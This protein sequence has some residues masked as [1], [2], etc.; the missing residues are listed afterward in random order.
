MKRP[1]EKRDSDITKVDKHTFRDPV[2]QDRSALAGR[3]KEKA[4]TIWLFNKDAAV[5]WTRKKPADKH[6]M[7]HCK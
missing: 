2:G 3:R 1:Y 7:R 6:A 4:I 5:E